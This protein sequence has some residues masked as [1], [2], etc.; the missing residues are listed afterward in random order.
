VFS[1]RLFPDYIASFHLRDGVTFGT[2]NIY[3]ISLGYCYWRLPI[4]PMPRSVLTIYQN[5]NGNLSIAISGVALR[6]PRK[7]RHFN[8]PK[9]GA[10]RRKRHG[11][12]LLRHTRVSHDGDATR[13]QATPYQAESVL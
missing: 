8:S 3:F 7:P 5:R 2:D 12:G 11:S 9:I 1:I 13:Y 10:G 6:S 4:L